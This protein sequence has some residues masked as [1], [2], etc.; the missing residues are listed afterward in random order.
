MKK[1]IG[2]IILVLIVIISVINHLPR[3]WEDISQIT[4]DTD[5]I[6]S[7][8]DIHI[9]NRYKETTVLEVKHLDMDK[10]IDIMNE[11]KYRRTWNKK[12]H[13]SSNE[14]IHYM[15]GYIYHDKKINIDIY[16]D[17]IIK[18]NHISYYVAEGK[19]KSKEKVKE[20]FRFMYDATNKE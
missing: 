10:F 18:I 6:Y 15:R 2:L 20:I 8:F 9:L 11:N 3:T 13:V 14:K 1:Y 16:S 19:E 4:H 7:K 12:Y 17:G 5:I